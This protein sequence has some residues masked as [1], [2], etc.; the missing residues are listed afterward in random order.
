MIFCKMCTC[1][2]DCVKYPYLDLPFIGDMALVGVP[3]A[4]I[5]LRGVEVL[6]GGLLSFKNASLFGD[7]ALYPDV[8]DADDLR[9][10]GFEYK[11]SLLFKVSKPG[12]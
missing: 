4:D 12:T 5:P 10:M 2:L 11:G 7:V 3:D 9:S 8:G 6:A 1:I